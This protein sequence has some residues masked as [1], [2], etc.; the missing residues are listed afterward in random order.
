MVC[1]PGAKPCLQAGW[2]SASIINAIDRAGVRLYV[3]LH[4][5]FP[6]IAPARSFRLIRQAGTAPKLNGDDTRC[7]PWIALKSR[8]LVR[9]G[10]VVTCAPI[11]AKKLSAS[12]RTTAAAGSKPPARARTNVPRATVSAQPDNRT[13]GGSPGLRR[14]CAILCLRDNAGFALAVVEVSPIAGP[15]PIKAGSSPGAVEITRASIR[16]GLA[17]AASCPPLAPA[18]ISA[19]GVHP[20]KRRARPLT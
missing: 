13:A 1:L 9:V 7:L 2:L 5:H 15:D 20:V 6:A 17:A 14:G 3:R 8:M 10:P 11:A 19:R 4:S 12:F 18:R 16:A